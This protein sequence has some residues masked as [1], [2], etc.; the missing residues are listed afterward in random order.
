MTDTPR[1]KAELLAK[2]ATIRSGKV[3][4]QDM[5]DFVVSS[6]PMAAAS[7]FAD[8][9]QTQVFTD[10]KYTPIKYVPT[11]GVDPE[12]WFTDEADYDSGYTDFPVPQGGLMRLPPGWYDAWIYQS[13]ST[14]ALASGADVH[15]GLQYADDPGPL[16]PIFGGDMYGSWA[17]P[18]QNTVP[19]NTGF[20]NITG[21][22]TI[23]IPSRDLSNTPVT[24]W[25]VCAYFS[26]NHQGVDQHQYFGQI[27]IRRI[28]G[29]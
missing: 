5:R 23:R 18:V 11:D 22:D 27:L 6:P 3:S 1:T 21:H 16:D 29:A 12:G 7:R 28:G 26:L 15:V 25:P 19:A 13:W 2:F 17:L 9:S 20:K 24:T 14:D 4:N 10:L 8:F